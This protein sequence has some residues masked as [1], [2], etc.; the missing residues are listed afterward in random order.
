MSFIWTLL[1]GGMSMP[2]T[3]TLGQR[4]ARR[5]GFWLATRHPAADIHPSCRISPEAKINPRRDR[6]V[7]GADSSIA[8]GA[9]VQGNIQM[10]H[11]CSIQAYA[12]IV[13]YGPD[14]KITIGDYVRIAP[15]VM[16][17]AANH[18]FDDLSQPI[19]SQ[20]LAPAPITIEDDVWIA[21]QVILT[22]GVTVGTGSVIGAGSVVTK[23]I[24]PYSVAAGSPAKVIKSRKSPAVY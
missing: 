18:N 14:G 12:V 24:P 20:G 5:V 7:I 19:H 21:S 23:D 2:Q 16:M 3:N 13:G 22:A 17:F 11:H 9:V 6:I 4:I 8:L 1:E 15:G 10:G